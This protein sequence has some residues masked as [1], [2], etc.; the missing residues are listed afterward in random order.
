MTVFINILA[1]FLEDKPCKSRGGSFLLH[2]CKSGNKTSRRHHLLQEAPRCP[3]SS[4]PS[5]LFSPL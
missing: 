4:Q 5:M 3:A 1:H 2:G